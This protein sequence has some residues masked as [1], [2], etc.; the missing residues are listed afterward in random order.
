MFPI[1]N[2]S[3]QLQGIAWSNNGRLSHP[4]T[5]DH[6]SPIR[7]CPRQKLESW[8]ATEGS[9]NGYLPSLTFATL[10]LPLP[11]K[12]TSETRQTTGWGDV[13]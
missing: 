9:E 11:A 8:T 12:R 1:S 7:C 10:P 2:V 3:F 13:A 4:N 6:P 5:S